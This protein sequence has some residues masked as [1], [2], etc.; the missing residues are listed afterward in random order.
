MHVAQHESSWALWVRLARGRDNTRELL[1]TPKRTAARN[2]FKFITHTVL[3]LLSSDVILFYIRGI[4]LVQVPSMIY[5]N[6]LQVADAILNIYAVYLRRFSLTPLLT[7]TLLG[8]GQCVSPLLHFQ[9]ANPLS[10]PIFSPLLS[11]LNFRFH[12]LCSP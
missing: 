11:I 3:E 5:A 10:S 2:D 12:D 8:A 9:F 6:G 7:S 4:D 1:T